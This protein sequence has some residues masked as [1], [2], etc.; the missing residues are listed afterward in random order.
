MLLS[1]MGLPTRFRKGVYMKSRSVTLALSAAF[2][3]TSPFIAIAGGQPAKAVMLS[4]ADMQDRAGITRAVHQGKGS[5]MT[6]RQASV[7]ASAPRTQTTARLS[8]TPFTK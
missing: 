4:K 2:A 8:D 6:R 3:L 1:G 5:G 7:P